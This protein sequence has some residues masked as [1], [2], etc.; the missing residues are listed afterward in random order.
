MSDAPIDPPTTTRTHQAV[1][2]ILVGA[3][4]VI[5]AIAER[6]LQHRPA[7]EL[8]GPKTLWR[9]LC[10]NVLGVIGYY[11]WGRRPAGAS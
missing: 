1:V 8:R 3:G 10:L 2:S 6:D 7:A 9:M 5:V 4:V 11:R